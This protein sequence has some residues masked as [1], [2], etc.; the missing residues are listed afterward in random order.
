MLWTLFAYIFFWVAFFCF[1]LGGLIYLS[2]RTRSKWLE[3]FSSRFGRTPEETSQVQGI[4]RRFGIIFLGAGILFL[5]ISLPS[6][7]LSVEDQGKRILLA[8]ACGALIFWQIRG[9]RNLVKRQPQ[10]R[11]KAKR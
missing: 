4:L 3:R 8:M 6:D 2:G 1:V 5:L 10:E 9:I 11:L 7:G